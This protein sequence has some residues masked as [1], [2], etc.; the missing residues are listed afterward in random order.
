MP[1]DDKNGKKPSGKN[2][3]P[4]DKSCAGS[5]QYKIYEDVVEKKKVK[6]KDVFDKKSS[7]RQKK[8][9]KY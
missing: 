7:P 6:E 3:K 1:K 2:M 8:S 4:A 9:K 5:C